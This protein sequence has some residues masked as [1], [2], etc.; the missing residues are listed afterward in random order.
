M[1]QQA[2]D[3]QRFHAAMSCLRRDQNTL[4]ITV[5]AGVFLLHGKG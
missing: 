3:Q 1:V 2:A 5:A 4:D